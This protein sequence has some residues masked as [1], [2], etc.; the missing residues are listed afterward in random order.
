MYTVCLL[1]FYPIHGGVSV[2]TR[3]LGLSRFLVLLQV[4]SFLKFLLLMVR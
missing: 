4:I 1:Y 3:A 2:K